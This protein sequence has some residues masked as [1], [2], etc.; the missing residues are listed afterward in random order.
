M[1]HHERQHDREGPLQRMLCKK[2]KNVV[3]LMSGTSVDGVDAVLVQ[4]RGD[5]LNLRYH[6]QGFVT[7]PFPTGLRDLILRNSLPETSRVDEIARLNMLLPQFYA[8]A[9]RRLVRRAGVSLRTIDLIGSHGQ[10]IQHVPERVT[11]AGRSVRATLQIGDPSAL[12]KMTGIPTVGDFRVAD[13]AVGGEGAPLVPFFDF[14]TFRSERKS[15]ALLNIGGIANITILPRSCTIDDVVAFDTGPGNM[16]VDALMKRF[17][18]RLLDRNGGHARR[19]KV[20]E[21]FVAELLRHP[22]IRRR[23]PKSTGREAFGKEFV[24]LLLA[25]ARALSCRKKEDIIRTAT[26]LTARSIH[27][28][29]RRFIE[30][31]TRIDELVVSGGGAHN[32]VIMTRLGELFSPAEVK[33]AEDIGISSD[34]KE[35]I[36]FALL[37]VATIQGTPGNLPRVTGAKRPVVLGKVCW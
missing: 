20:S 33:R 13:M 5:G 21:R 25:R 9:V 26:E 10:T 7:V 16:V 2:V 31:V 15:M 11:L 29:Y 8:E 18:G 12:A 36:C 24:G 3:G 1:Q 37:A 35:A 28:N 30:P 34:A 27:E 22:F 4:V 14:V 19:G 23:P 6:Q 17:Y 32:R